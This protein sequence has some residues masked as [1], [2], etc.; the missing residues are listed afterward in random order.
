LRDLRVS[1]TASRPLDAYQINVRC[2]D[3]FDGDL[4]ALEI[5]RFDSRNWEASFKALKR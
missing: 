2:L 3:D 1:S 4:A 5:N